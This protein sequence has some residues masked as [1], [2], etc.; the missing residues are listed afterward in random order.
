[1]EY[2]WFIL[3]IFI[4]FATAEALSSRLFKK[5]SEVRDDGIVEILS[6]TLLFA[7]TQPFILFS[8]ALLVALTFPEY[9][10]ILAD[11][12][13]WLIFL[14]FVVFDDMTQYWWHRL[15]H[16][17]IPLY[18]LHRAHHNAH[19]MSVRIVYRNNFFYYLLMPSLWLSGVIIYLGGGWVY[20]V[21]LIAKLTII[22]GAHCEWKWDRWLYQQR[23]T[24]P[25]MWV[26]ER[27]ISTPSTHSAHHG[28][29]KDDPATHYK[30]N[31]SN[32]F[33]IWDLLF[34]TAKIT[35][36]YPE[37]YGVEGMRSANWKE[38]LLWQLFKTPR[39]TPPAK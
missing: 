12:P 27:V 37:R 17:Y 22:T 15:S 5:Q 20:G 24:R 26:L 36:S 32:M 16:T 19:Y 23:A 7:V 28:L 30:G 13:F 35:R 6:T 14:M 38:Q 33:F 25:L 31:Y 8:S 3:A 9:A 4:G 29:K 10:N 1:M 39:K 2:Q 21:Y 18:K 11:Q 34:G